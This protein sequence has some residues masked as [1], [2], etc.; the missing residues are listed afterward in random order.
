MAI[1]LLVDY[2]W[3]TFRLLLRVVVGVRG[4]L[5]LSIGETHLLV[6]LVGALNDLRINLH[7]DVAGQRNL[8]LILVEVLRIGK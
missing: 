6:E 7:V 3:N 1:L 4:V 8:S 2:G 5:G